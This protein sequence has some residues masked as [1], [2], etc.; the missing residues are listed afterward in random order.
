MTADQY[1]YYLPS[2][3]WVSF[4]SIG[5]DIFEDVFELIDENRNYIVNEDWTKFK[6]T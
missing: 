1:L 2:F 3:E 6:K 4:D 5:S